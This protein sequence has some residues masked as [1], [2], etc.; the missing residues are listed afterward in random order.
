MR[1]GGYKQHMTIIHSARGPERERERKR[2]KEIH[3]S[4]IPT[5]TIF[6]AMTWL[7]ILK[8]NSKHKNTLK[9]QADI[10]AITFSAVIIS[11]EY[12]NKNI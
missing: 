12:I 8:I 9:Y 10:I 1:L 4:N 7:A 2:E 5:L 3:L 6:I 11:P